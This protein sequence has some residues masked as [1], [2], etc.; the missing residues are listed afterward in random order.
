MMY[1]ERAKHRLR[2]RRRGGL[3]GG[4]GSSQ[5]TSQRLAITLGC[6]FCITFPFGRPSRACQSDDYTLDLDRPGGREK[7]RG[8]AADDIYSKQS[9]STVSKSNKCMAELSEISIWHRLVPFGWLLRVVTANAASS[10]YSLC[11]AYGLWERAG[12]G[13]IVSDQTC[14]QFHGDLHTTMKTSSAG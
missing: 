4:S 6:C 9:V 5:V 7:T 2:G 1:T 3:R 11:F 12:G 8:R 13:K 10:N 14:I